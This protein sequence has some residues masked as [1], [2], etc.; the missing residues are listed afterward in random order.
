MHV[1]VHI[2]GDVLG[3]SHRE[4]LSG[5]ASSL[6]GIVQS[7]GTDNRFSV[8]V[9]FLMMAVLMF[10]SGVAFLMLWRAPFAQGERRSAQAGSDSSSYAGAGLMSGHQVR[11]HSPDTLQPTAARGTQAVS[12]LATTAPQG[13][14]ATRSRSADSAQQAA[15]LE[16]TMDSPVIPRHVVVTHASPRP[17]LLHGDVAARPVGCACLRLSAVSSWLLRDQMTALLVLAWASCLENGIIMSIRTYA[18]LPFS[19]GSAVRT[20]ALVR[21]AWWARCDDCNDSLPPCKQVLLW[22]GILVTMVD[23]FAASLSTWPALRC[24]SL[25]TL[26]AVFSSGGAV[27]VALALSSPSPPLHSVA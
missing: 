15:Q 3:A 11:Y 9:F 10:I 16:V 26:C 2:K 5:V 12:P 8:T 1:K 21:V 25:K 4:G 22:T 17:A 24:Y 27:I 14:D 6:L 18:T 19:H 20:L 13:S 23:P 7:P